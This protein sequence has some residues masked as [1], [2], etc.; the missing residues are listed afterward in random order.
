[1]RAVNCPEIKTENARQEE[2]MGETY[3]EIKSLAIFGK[4][5]AD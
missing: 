2:E 3:W 1:L 4:T 5:N